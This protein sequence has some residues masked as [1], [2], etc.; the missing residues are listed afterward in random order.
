VNIT[1]KQKEI[2]KGCAAE[3][4]SVDKK[5]EIVTCDIKKYKNCL[6]DKLLKE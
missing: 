2:I 3:S 6:N 1:E 5:K 4:I